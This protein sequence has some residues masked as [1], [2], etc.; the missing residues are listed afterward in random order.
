ML[1]PLYISLSGI[2]Y[3]D[4][5]HRDS[6]PDGG[7]QVAHG[8]VKASIPGDGDNRGL[9]GGKLRADSTGDAVPDGG[10]SPV[11][12]EGTARRRGV[13][14]KARPVSGKSTVGKKNPVRRHGSG[15]FV[16][17]PRHVNRL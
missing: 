5:S 15:Q 7:L 13:V 14:Q 12:D 2:V 1:Q 17:Q 3:D 9:L 4:I 11:H 6:L 10:V 16:T 8:H